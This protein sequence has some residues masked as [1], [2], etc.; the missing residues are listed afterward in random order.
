MYGQINILFIYRKSHFLIL[1]QVVKDKTKL[2]I[3]NE[4]NNKL[5]KKEEKHVKI[6]NIGKLENN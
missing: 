3:V 1:K 5:K 4:K 2:S 6:N